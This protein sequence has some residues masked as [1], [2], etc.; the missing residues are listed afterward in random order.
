MQYFGRAV[1]DVRN[2]QAEI[3]AAGLSL[4]KCVIIDTELSGEWPGEKS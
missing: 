4:K 2:I 3:E 1:V